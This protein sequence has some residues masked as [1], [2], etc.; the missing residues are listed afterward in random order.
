[1]REII[2]GK[3]EEGYRMLA[4]YVEEF[5]AKNPVS[6]CFINWIDEDLG[7]NPT[8]KHLFIGIGVAI[9][10]FKEHCASFHA[11]FY[12]AANAYSACVHE[13]AM[14]QIKQKEAA[15]YRWLRDTEPLE[16]WARFKFDQTLKCPD[17]TNNF[18]ENFN[19]AI[20]NFRGKPVFTML[21]DIRKL[22]GG[23]FVKK[24]EKAQSWE[25]KII[26]IPCKHAARC[27]L[28]IKDKLENYC[29][30][31]FEVENDR[32]LYDTIVG[33]ISTPTMWESRTLP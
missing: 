14:E 21:E 16:H 1:M 15:A 20:L 10:S 25:G 17:N 6:T 26:G 12:T 7:K 30:D 5:K 13:K 29:D 18:V 28:R 9:S 22:V 8:F 4:H 32:K 2:E 31:C 11:Y 33:P 19:H 3:H 23:R 24:F 27:I